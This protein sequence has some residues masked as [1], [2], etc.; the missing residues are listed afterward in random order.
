MESLAEAPSA[1]SL[2]LRRQP[3]PLLAVLPASRRRY[4]WASRVRRS[5]FG[6]FTTYLNGRQHG[7]HASM[8]QTRCCFYECLVE[9]NLERLSPRK[10]SRDLHV[11]PQEKL[12]NR[13][14]TW[15]RGTIRGGKGT[16][17]MNE[18]E[19][20]VILARSFTGLPLSTQC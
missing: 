12:E 11:T 7:H 9:T 5:L 4:S 10:L 15:G 6:D 1:W 2:A 19:A 17:C 18:V 13:I 20:T 3:P 16:C 8:S 14:N